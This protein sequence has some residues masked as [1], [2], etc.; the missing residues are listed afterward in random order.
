MIKRYESDIEEGAFILQY[1]RN[2]KE[3]W[4]RIYS[5]QVR[6]VLEQVLIPIF[7]ARFHVLALAFFMLKVLRLSPQK[8]CVASQR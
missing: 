4:M 1:E 5:D 6:T 3:K 2:G 8:T 7:F